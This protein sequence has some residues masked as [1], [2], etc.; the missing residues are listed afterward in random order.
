MD[1]NQEKQPP[2]STAG[3]TGLEA[4]WS[5]RLIS[6]ACPARERLAARPWGGGVC[7]LGLAL[8]GSSQ[9]PQASTR[10]GSYGSRAEE[11]VRTCPWDLG[12]KHR[13]QVLLRQRQSFGE[14]DVSS[15]KGEREK[16]RGL[17]RRGRMQWAHPG[18]R[19]ALAQLQ[20]GHGLAVP[21]AALPSLWCTRKPSSSH[22][23]AAGSHPHRTPTPRSGHWLGQTG[24]WAPRPWSC[25]VRELGEG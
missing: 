18:A 21:P 10:E 1:Q 12:L 16:T 8:G 9:L 17:A 4:V 25:A 11:T 24:C 14:S 19:E 23:L 22:L 2:Y 5:Q 20:P 3:G 6:D 15:P 7:A 13:Q